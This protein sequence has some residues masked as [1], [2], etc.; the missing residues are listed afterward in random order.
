M[1]CNIRGI[2]KPDKLICCIYHAWTKSRFVDR[3]PLYQFP[4]IWNNWHK[5][6]NV[7]TSHSGLMRTIKLLTYM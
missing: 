3:L 1:N 2:M 6:L 7:Y 4:E 5:Q